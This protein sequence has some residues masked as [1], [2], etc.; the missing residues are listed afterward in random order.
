M[1]A[2]VPV[3]S[4]DCAAGPRELIE[5]EVNGLLVAPD[6]VPGWPPPCSAWRPTTS[7]G[8]LGAGRVRGPRGS[9]RRD[10]LAQQWE[11]I[12]RSVARRGSSVRRTGGCSG[13][14]RSDTDAAAPPSSPSARRRPGPRPARPGARPW[15]GRSADRPPRQRRPGSSIPAHD[16][17]G[18]DGRRA[19]AGA[20]TR[21]LRGS[22]QGD[23]PRTSSLVDPGDCGWPERRGRPASS[24]ATCATAAPRPCCLEP[25]PRPPRRRPCSPRTPAS[26]S[27]SGRRLPDGDLVAP[28]P[29]RYVARVPRRHRDR[30]RRDRR[31][32]RPDP[33]ADDA[34]DRA[35]SA[36]P[37]RRRL[38]LGRRRR[39]G[40]ER[41]PRAAAGAATGTARPGVERPGP[42]RRPRRAAV[43]D[44]QRA[45][46]RPVGAPDPPRHRR[47]GARLA[48]RR[49]TR[50]SGSSTTARSCPA[51]ALPTFNSQAI[52]TAL[53]R[54]PDL[55]EH[56]VYVNDDVFLGR[57]TRPELFFTP[58][59]D[60]AAFVGDGR[61]AAGPGRHAVPQGRGNNRRL[62]EEAF[63][64]AITQV[65]AHS[66]H[67]HRVSVLA[68]IE[69]RFAEAVARTAR[70]PF[71][72]DTD[73]S[74]LS[75]LAQHYG[76]VTGTSYVAR[77]NHAFVDLS[78][79]G[80]S[81]SSPA[82]RPRPGLL[83]H[84][85]P[86]RVRAADA[87]PWTRCCRSSSA[88]YFPV[89][90]PV[91]ALRRRRVPASGD[92]GPD[93]QR[94][95]ATGRR[96]RRV[97]ASSAHLGARGVELGDGARRAA[98][99]SCG[100]RRAGRR[101]PGRW[102]RPWRSPRRSRTARRTPAAPGQRLDR[103]RVGRR[104]H[105]GVHG[106]PGALGEVA[107]VGRDGDVVPG[108]GRA[109]AA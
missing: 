94:S 96:A 30:R 56:W 93:G 27:S 49:T 59:G 72:S 50:R 15:T 102:S 24:P 32:P 54:V 47:P 84:R 46:L 5:H 64:V 2:G 6:S 3:V 57:R 101:R 13:V 43:L 76:L 82:P 39:P 11:E 58:G 55:T 80:S 91:G 36:V 103:G 78:D 90:A 16:G 28:R 52:E 41:G 29:N 40:L 19:D 14:S 77:P 70:S 71:R 12:F 86:P 104:V 66:P 51:D 63:G 25:W 73:V 95:A 60:V 23:G 97:A 88:S 37:D 48:G 44:A 53:H 107:E 20:R 9:T 75:S 99:P 35:T 74:L 42:L 21:F 108:D 100:V 31:R 38:H 98:R 87:E 89:A 85:R 81:G 68:E 105:Q 17:D 79:A 106:L 4:F 65:L 26:R 109:V 7:S 10:V 22:T 1:A 8:R 34:A 62:L 92:S 18:A 61:R 67:P 33:A 69:E 45:P 83:L